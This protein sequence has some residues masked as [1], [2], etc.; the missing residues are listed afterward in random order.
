MSYCLPL[1]SRNCPNVQGVLISRVRTA[2]FRTGPYFRRSL[3]E[4]STTSSSLCSYLYL[5][6]SQTERWAKT[7]TSL[8]HKMAEC[9]SEMEEHELK[10]EL[11]R[12]Q[13]ELARSGRDQCKQQR[14]T[15]QR[16]VCTVCVCVH[17]TLLYRI[18]LFCESGTPP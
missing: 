5:C 8:T 14:M 12:K 9:E 10:I 15:L 3:S 17:D 6:R 11:L 16:K 1:S 2:V 4:G 7:L 13:L 18:T